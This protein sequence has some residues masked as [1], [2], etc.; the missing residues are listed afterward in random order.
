MKHSKYRNTG[1]LFELITRQITADILNKESKSSAINI[2][3]KNFNKKSQLFKENQ[4]FNVIIEAKYADK[5]RAHH[6]VET[7][8]KAYNKVIDRKKLQREKYELI[9]QIKENFDIND[10]FKSHVSNYRLLAAINNV[11]H[12][13][14]SNPA[15]NSK[16]HFTIVEHITRKVEKKEAQLLDKMRKENKDLRSLAYKILVEKFNNKYKSLLPEQ[17][18]VLKE[19]INNISNTNGLNEFMESKFKLIS[20]SLKKVFPKIGNKVV[21]IK[22]RECIKLIEEVDTSKGKITDNVLKLMRFYQLLE[23]VKH[24][25]RS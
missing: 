24:A 7:T 20:H 5:D 8:I 4:L 23:D 16:N 9:K 18:N 1:L 6:L 19:F 25:V 13:D 22:I 15:V 14:Y 11:L 21:K 10:F 12:E 3:K 2:L 17:K